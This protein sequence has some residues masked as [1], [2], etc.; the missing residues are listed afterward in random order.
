[1]RRENRESEKSR[2]N[3]KTL[4]DLVDDL[5]PFSFCFS[6]LIMFR[7]ISK[8]TASTFKYTTSLFSQYNHD[9]ITSKS[10]ELWLQ[11]IQIGLVSFYHCIYVKLNAKL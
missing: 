3:D 7:H 11:D 9:S 5:L 1:M 4:Q 6:P 10:V 2:E 8:I